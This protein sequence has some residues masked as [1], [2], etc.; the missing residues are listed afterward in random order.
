MDFALDE[1][2]ELLREQVR[3]FAEERIA[4]GV[5]E[6]DRQHRFPADIMRE[7]GELGL[8]GMFVP[9]RYGG[10][11]MGMVSYAVAVE[12]SGADLSGGGGDDERHQLGLLLADSH[13]W[14]RGGEAECAARARVGRVRSAGS[15]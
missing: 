3:R 4:P 6:R 1:E 14:R 12:E 13:L 8:L 10:A 15:A 9:E 11:G 2:Q 5:A 7:M